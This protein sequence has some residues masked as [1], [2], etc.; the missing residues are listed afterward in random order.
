MKNIDLYPS[1]TKAN[2]LTWL[3]SFEPGTFYVYAL[4]DHSFNQL[5]IK[6]LKN[7]ISW[8]SLYQEEGADTDISPILC[9]LNIEDMELFDQQIDVL[10]QATKEQPMLSFWLSALEPETVYEHFASYTDV[11]ILP[12]KLSYLLRYADTRILPNLLNIMTPLQKSQFLGAFYAGSYF[13]RAAEL[14]QLTGSKELQINKSALC[15]TELQFTQLLDASQPDQIIQ[16][17]KKLSMTNESAMSESQIY[18][19]VIHLCTEA[20]TAGLSDFS[21]VQ[22]YCIEQFIT[23]NSL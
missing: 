23:D 10:L 8:V 16:R 6:K 2:I 4:I 11:V 5:L 17:L 1:E 21:E 22:S 19:R 7:L 18:N 20:N 13:N 12:E 3:T 14:I 9:H 15:I